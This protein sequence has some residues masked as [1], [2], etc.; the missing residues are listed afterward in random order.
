MLPFLWLQ[1]EPFLMVFFD[2]KYCTFTLG[3]CLSE[4]SCLLL[5]HATSGGR[6]PITGQ[7]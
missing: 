6:Y 5:S 4:V 2:F 1:S 3:D 7:G